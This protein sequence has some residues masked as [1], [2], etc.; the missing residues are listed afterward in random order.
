MRPE[1]C[2][3]ALRSRFRPEAA[4]GVNEVYQLVIDQMPFV[5]RVT[6]GELEMGS[7]RAGA[8]QVSLEC[9]TVTAAELASGRVDAE[10][11][12]RRGDLRIA[13]G[14]FAAARFARLFGLDGSQRTAGGR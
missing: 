12:E 5:A 2:A 14:S 7:G 6:S 11:A 3:L 1:W 8:P 4:A 9:D 10:S 13:G